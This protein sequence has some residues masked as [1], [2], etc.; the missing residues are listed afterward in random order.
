MTDQK[1]KGKGDRLQFL[2]NLKT[3]IIFLVVVYH[4]GYVY[5][6][7]GM[8]SIIWIVDDPAKN[9]LAGQ[10][11]LILDMFM[12]PI[13][14]FISDFFAPI[15]LKSKNGWSFV[16][17]RFKRL[18]IPWLIAILTLIPLYRVIF[19][20]SRGLPPGKPDL[21]LPFQWRYADEPRVALVPAGFILV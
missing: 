12:M 9:S 15:S 17:S 7:S 10:V 21:L 16:L 14:F 4:A 8:L 18:M 1:I 11:G 6:G 5:E 2:D 19:L 13:M 3:F 20:F